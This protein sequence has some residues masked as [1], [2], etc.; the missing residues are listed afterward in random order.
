MSAKAAREIIERAMTDRTVYDAMAARESEV[1]GRLLPALE[2][3]EARVE[4][5]KASAE[6]RVSRYQTSLIQAAKEK[7]LKFERGL[8]LG[9]PRHRGR[10]T[11]TIPLFR[12]PCHHHDP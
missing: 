6:L 5:E 9:P 11:L 2:H 3:S 8:T 10:R 4:D 12:F 7:G 1:W